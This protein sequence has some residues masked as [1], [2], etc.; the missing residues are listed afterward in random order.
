[1]MLLAVLTLVEVVSIWPVVTFISRI[2]TGLAVAFAQVIF[3]SIM[4]K[5][6]APE[7]IGRTNGIITPLMMLGMLIGSASSGFIVLHMSLFGAY[8]IAAILTVIG[9]IVTTKLT[10][11]NK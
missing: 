6:V 11:Q 2:L 3:S 9:A 10:F 5:Q 8:S 4:I 7:Y 1:M